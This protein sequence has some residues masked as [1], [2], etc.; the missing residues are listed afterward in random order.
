M[1][2][3][4]T[5]LFFATLFVAAF[6]F[7]SCQKCATCQYTY[8]GLNG[9]TETFTYSQVCGNNGDVNDYKDACSDAAAAFTNGSCNCVDD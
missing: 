3:I 2:R 6:S 1:K 4:L 7:Q 9:E 8:T 5:S